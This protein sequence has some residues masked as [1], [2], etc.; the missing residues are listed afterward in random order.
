MPSSSARRGEG[1]RVSTPSTRI[2]PRSGFTRPQRIPISVDLP[3]PFSPS[4]QWISPARRVRLMS[5]LART[6][7]NAFVMP[8]SSTSG[9]AWALAWLT[10]RLWPDCSGRPG[11]RLPRTA[12]EGGLAVDQLLD[13]TL[14]VGNLDLDLAGEDLGL[15]LRDRLPHFRGDVLRLQQRDA[16]LQC[17]VVAVRPVA[18]AVHVVD[19]LLEDLG[20]VPQ[21]GG[22]E[23]MVL[24]DRG[25][26][27]DV[28]D[29]PDL[30][31]DLGVA[32]RLEV[33]E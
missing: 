2:R 5:S 33:A 19:G 7:G 15:R 14:V 30:V 1:I 10:R 16:V 26:V 29:H 9:G 28:A 12:R 21:H 27:A 11:W 4:K 25:H 22:E 24:V 20:E 32:D 3:A 13:L 18:A 17:E 8:R 23:D 31:T 6:F